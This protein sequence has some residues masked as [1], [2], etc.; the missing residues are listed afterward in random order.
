MRTVSSRCRALFVQ[1]R[2]PAAK[3]GMAAAKPGMAAAKPGMAARM[4]A[5]SLA[6]VLGAAGPALLGCGGEVVV[7]DEAALSGT[8]AGASSGMPPSGSCQLCQANVE[9]GHCLIQGEDETYRCPP[10]LPPPSPGCLDLLEEHHDQYGQL[11][12]CYY[13][14]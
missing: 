1:R 5:L 13:C 4:R 9:C 3:P 2:T 6:T 14:D 12:T 10:S 8:G 7:G 11:Y